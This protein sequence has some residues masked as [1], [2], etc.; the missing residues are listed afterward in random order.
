MVD[1]CHEGQLCTMVGD[2]EKGTAINTPRWTDCASVNGTKKPVCANDNVL[3]VNHTLNDFEDST[4]VDLPDELTIRVVESDDTPVDGPKSD[5]T[6]GLEEF[7]DAG[8]ADSTK[9]VDVVRNSINTSP[10]IPASH[11]TTSVLRKF[12]SS[13]TDMPESMSCSAELLIS[14]SEMSNNMPLPQKHLN[15]S[16]PEHLVEGMAVA[17]TT[18]A[19]DPPAMTR[20][21]MDPVRESAVTSTTDTMDLDPSSV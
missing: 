7:N 5:E 13:D 12:N 17:N 2:I 6:K 21:V 18:A 20:T 4:S 9:T 16:E 1:D 15:D 14:S 10:Q 11:H 8:F 3:K 19:I